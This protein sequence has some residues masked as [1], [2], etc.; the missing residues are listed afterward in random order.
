MTGISRPLVPW[1]AWGLLFACGS[2]PAAPEGDDNPPDAT[3]VL[4]WSREGGF[5]GFCDELK[6]TAAGDVAASSCKT[7][8][9]RTRK[10]SSE[11]AA[12]LNDWRRAFGRV[13]ITSKDSASA[14]AMTLKITLAGN[15]R[16][17][18]SDAQR[19]ELLDWAQRIYSQTTG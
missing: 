15:G 8:G 6:V 11:D 7:A 10:L 14:D 5:A 4:S 3:V 19:L 18:P 17:Q 12:R 2:S 1:L 13:D 9:V 16:D